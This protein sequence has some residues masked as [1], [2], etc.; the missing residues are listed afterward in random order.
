MVPRRRIGG[1]RPVAVETL[2][3][4]MAAVEGLRPGVGDGTM[5]LGKIITVRSRTLPVD[6]GALAPA[7]AGD[8]HGQSQRWFANVASQTTLLG[9]AGGA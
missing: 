1:V 6:H 2:R 7:R 4:D 8:R 3:T 5:Q 9:V